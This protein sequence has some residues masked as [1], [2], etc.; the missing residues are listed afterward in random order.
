MAWPGGGDTNQGAG[1]V[2]ASVLH[3]AF[4]LPTSNTDSPSAEQGR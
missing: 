4:C 1:L 3:I 2:E